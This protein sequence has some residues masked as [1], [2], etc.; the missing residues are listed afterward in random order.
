MYKGA[1]RFRCGGALLCL[2][3][4]A[5]GVPVWAGDTPAG[6]EQAAPAASIRATTAAAVSPASEEK[7]HAA[8]EHL[9]NLEFTPAV[10][11][12]EQVAQAEPESATV[13][14]FW[15]SAILYEMLARQGTLQ[16]QLFVTTNE[17]LRF[18]RIPPDPELDRRFHAVVQETERRAAKRL[19]R[20]RDDVD[21]LFALGLVRGNVANY[22][23]GV[24]AEYLK[25]LRAGEESFEYMQR[26]R[27][28]NPEIHDAGVVLGVHDYIIGTLPRTHRF[29]LFFLGSTGNR[30]RGVA[31]LEEAATQGEFLRTY[32][33]VL[34]VV[35]NTR[36]NNV[37]RSLSLGKDLLQ[38]YP[39]NPVFLLEVARM[40]RELEQYSD[41][42]R[43]CRQF[44]VEMLVHP[45][46]PRIL[47]P[48]DGLLELARIEAAQNDFDRALETLARIDDVPNVNQ[49]IAA[50]A[51]LERGKILDQLGRRE[52]ALA[53][54]ERVIVAAAD[55]ELTRQAR[56]YQKRAYR[57]EASN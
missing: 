33:Q 4:L 14:A 5:A 21:A 7:L 27:R 13:C 32:A 12:F 41:A 42:I 30:E 55:P 8:F 35:A 51:R 38:R 29:L 1:V 22:L 28:L 15:A 34:L 46:N 24:K 43:L 54:Y 6:D 57:P 53:E 48:E 23:A 47:G 11:L 10:R 44:I 49:R 19:E 36:D 56:A 37:Q 25:G 31:Y 2:G 40:H 50:Q 9:Y 39:R 26:L 18:Q 3:L 52:L 20:N 45:H 16:S 17:F